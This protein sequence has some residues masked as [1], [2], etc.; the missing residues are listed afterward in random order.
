MN[1]NTTLITTAFAT[2]AIALITAGIAAPAAFATSETPAPSASSTA[3]PA[4]LP[5]ASPSPS[6]DYE[7]P[8]APTAEELAAAGLTVDGLTITPGIDSYTI[9]A[10][11]IHL[12]N[13]ATD[14]VF[15]I[16]DNRAHNGGVNYTD[17][18][19]I[20]AGNDGTGYSVTIPVDSGDYTVTVSAG[21][22]AADGS[23]L[24]GDLAQ[25]AVT[26]PAQ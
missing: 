22:S 2:G 23:P 18:V 5:S 24:L 12:A 7:S 6:V 20:T 21:S 16:G 3:S 11:S 4:E 19:D 13:G 25:V 17:W 15:S 26:V 9:S 14:A 10:D 1:K 8:V